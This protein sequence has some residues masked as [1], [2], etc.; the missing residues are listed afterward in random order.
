MHQIAVAW[1]CALAAVLVPSLAA[2]Q[3]ALERPTLTGTVRDASGA[4]L[5]GVTVEAS[6]PALIEKVRTAVT[7]GA[8][9]YR[10]VNLDPGVYTLTF[11]LEG[12]SQVK[13]EDI[14][15]RGS[16]TLT[17]PVEMK[18]G[19]ITETL[20]VSGESPVVD[21]QSTRREAV[22]DG[23][24]ISVLPGT[25]S[26][27]SLITMVPGVET[28]GAALN[29]SPGLVFFFSRGGPNSEGRFNVNGMPVANA[30]AGGGGSSLIYDTVNVDEI[31]FTVAGGMGETDVGGPVLNIV[32]RAGGNTFQGQA[33]TNF[34][35]D[36]L[37][38]DNLTPELTAPPPG[39]NLRQTPGIIKAYDANV[40]YGG[41]IVRDRLWF[42][43]SYRKLN[44]E[45]A[46]EGVVGN[47]NA[48]DLSRWDWAEDRSLTARTSAGRSIYI[49]RLT[50]QVAEKHRLSVNWESQ[51]RCDGTPLRAETDGCHTRG[52]NWVAA[53]A[54]SS[55][56]ASL[57]YLDVP[58]TVVQGRW[59]NPMT[60]K[61]LLEAG[62]TY[63]SYRHA[64]GFL[65]L[66]PDG[67]FDIGVTEQS[68]AI[69][70]ATG[71]QYAPRSNY[72][73]RAL[74]EYRDDTASPNNWNASLSYVT[75]SHNIKIGYQGAY[76]AASTIRHA[77]PTLLSYSFNQGVPT[78]FTVRI[79]EWGTADRTWTQAFFAQD[80]WTRGRV[81]FQGALRYDRAWSYS[82]EG[83]SGSQ[84]DAPQLGFS[85]ITFPRTPSVDAFNDITPRFGVA[86]DV[87]GTGK[88]A[89]KFSG[90]RYLGAATNGGPYTRNNPAVRTVSTVA[91]GWTD[92]DN[93]RVVDCNLGILTA[94]GECAALTGNNLNFGGLS[95]ITEQVN[96]DTLRG[97]GARDHDWQWSIGV[98]HEVFSRVS[99][100][101]AYA[102]RSFHSF[103]VTDNLN[104]DPSQYDAWTINAPSD[105]RL[106]DGGGYPITVY[107]PTAAA[108]AVPAQNYVTWET[109]FGPARTA[110]WQGVDFTA[111]ARTRQGLTL[112][113]GTN[114][115]RRKDDFCDTALRI[116]SPDW[117]T[118]G[119]NATNCR[120]TPPYQTTVRGLASYTIP[121]VDVLVSTA[122]RSQPPVARTAT[123]PVPN[124]V[125]LQILGRIPP[126]GTAGGN[127]NV[128][129]IDDDHQLYA[130]NR[131]TQIDLRVAKI[132]RFGTRRLDIG[133]DAE[134]LLNTNYTTT[135]DNTY[136]YSVGN[137]AAGGTWNNP[138]AIYTPRF[139][140]LNFTVSF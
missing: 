68:T 11:S 137:T 112:Q 101:V 138:T 123:W 98:Q 18:V 124:S 107:T 130:D 82:P 50:A 95:G 100:D 104:R 133:V 114:T 45:T 73:Y 4:V 97:W 135:Y 127:T 113:I 80:T 62:A 88:T 46:V 15:L 92:S 96:Q 115:G 55:P 125:V 7:D 44:T 24:V 74:S 84:V 25:R 77:N 53:T 109:D 65:S 122:I 70:P 116:D 78:T 99:V 72:V 36:R 103:T 1:V 52:A 71:R 89:L 117:R 38:G 140:R 64:G 14:E 51:Q 3:G 67:I 90:G 34:S 81:T 87:F 16:G 83:L 110:Y 94:N 42:F 91:R 128:A 43:G 28:F 76:Q 93:D 134:N 85:A 32:P 29:P 37:R 118:S 39:P 75:G 131:R 105:S 10:I 120:S 129:L 8:G 126:G 23:D 106:P 57:N 69:N 121:R 59:T 66:P 108:A 54:T 27:G 40:S 30:F 86:Y 22:I 136:Q 48:F 58:Y 102:R 6:S 13:R 2:A 111:N 26:T 35:N 49:G 5:P 41:P 19:N 63:Y 79:P 61:L 119:P 17:I 20:V 139:V 132:F 9:V 31:A 60:T 47:A 12:F 33:F 56:E 21:V